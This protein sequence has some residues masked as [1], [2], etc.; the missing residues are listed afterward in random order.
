MLHAG[1]SLEVFKKWCHDPK[2]MVIL[3]GYC[4]VGTVGWKIL[5]GEKEIQIDPWTKLQVN[6]TVENLSFSAHADCKGIM[7]MIRMC[8]PKNV[9]LVHG[10]KSKMAILRQRIQK[11]IGIPCY[12]PA[13]E[14]VGICFHPAHLTFKG[15]RIQE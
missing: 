13:N 8:A 6:L 7:Q 4:V 5:S 10:E 12:D 9:I 15:G 14:T 1:A 3:P 11:E 2:N